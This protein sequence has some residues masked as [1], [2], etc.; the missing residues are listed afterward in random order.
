M[1]SPERVYTRDFG[2]LFLLEFTVFVVFY[3]LLPTVPLYII[4]IGGTPAT[5]G[6]VIGIAGPVA[7]FGAPI[8]GLGVDRWSRKGMVV[9]GLA[10]NVVSV[11]VM[12]LIKNPLLM[13]GPALLRRIGSG[14]SGSGRAA[15]TSGM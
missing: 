4:D 14:A 15:T 3:M 9:V 12:I 7:A 2:L 6:W 13:L 8:Y 5:V 10:A 1:A 11:L